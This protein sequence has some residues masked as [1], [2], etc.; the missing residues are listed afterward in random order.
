[1]TSGSLNACPR[2][3]TP[4]FQVQP[5]GLPFIAQRKIGLPVSAATRRACQRS[6][7]HGIAC[8]C[9]SSGCG[10][11][12]AAMARK[13]GGAVAVT[14]RVP[15]EMRA[16]G[17]SRRHGTLRHCPSRGVS[18]GCVASTAKAPSWRY[19]ARTRRG[20]AS[21]KEEPSMPRCPPTD[22]LLAPPWREPPA[23]A[24]DHDIWRRYRC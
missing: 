20:C 5:S 1:M 12:C 15:F 17:A 4:L 3:A 10:A 7:S 14:V 6:T 8:H 11:T 19:A 22:G 21:G 9:N 16:H 23:D 18:P 13:S 24:R 2:A